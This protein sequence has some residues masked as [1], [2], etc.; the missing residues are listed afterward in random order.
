VEAP[1]G[2]AGDPLPAPAS[3]VAEAASAPPAIS[4]SPTTSSAGATAATPLASDDAGAASPDETT[5]STSSGRGEGAVSV[6]MPLDGGDVRAA[7]TAAPI[8][9]LD[10]AA[11]EPAPAVTDPE[12]ETP[13]R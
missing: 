4:S 2:G 8:N 9:A 11:P 10:A 6:P 7:S 13:Q 5:S 3:D 1:G 12:Q